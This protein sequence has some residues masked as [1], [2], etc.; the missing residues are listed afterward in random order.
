MI[1]VYKPIVIPLMASSTQDRY[2]ERAQELLDFRLL[3][4]SACEMSRRFRCSGI[5]P[6]WRLRLLSMNR[7]TRFVTC[8]RALVGRLCSTGSWLRTR[9]RVSG[10]RP[11]KKGEKSKPYVTPEQFDS[12]RRADSRT[13]RQYGFRC[14]VYGP[15]GERTGR[16]ALAEC[17]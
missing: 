3:A 1:E 7:R 13:L 11:P 9:S 12:V 5:F 16:T 10:F 4:S 14:R 8:F 2:Q 17:P 6:A 15:A